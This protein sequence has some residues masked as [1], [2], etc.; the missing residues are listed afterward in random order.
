MTNPVHQATRLRLQ[1]TRNALQHAIMEVNVSAFALRYAARS[2]LH[3]GGPSMAGEVTAECNRL[4][5][6]LDLMR[7]AIEI[8]HGGLSDVPAVLLFCVRGDGCPP[9]ETVRRLLGQGPVTGPNIYD[10]L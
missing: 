7:A 9:A 6:A 4:D 5:A 2:I 8:A 1:I 3:Y 10:P